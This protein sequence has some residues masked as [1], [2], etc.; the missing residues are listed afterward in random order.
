MITRIKDEDD[1]FIVFGDI[2]TC[3]IARCR[4][5]GRKFLRGIWPQSLCP[6]CEINEPITM[7][8]LVNGKAVIEEV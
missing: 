3:T 4:K 7:Y 2:G 5:C 8:S 1:E 6:R